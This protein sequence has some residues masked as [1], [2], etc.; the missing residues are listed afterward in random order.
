MSF[1]L[2]SVS[3]LA[4]ALALAP[5]PA[6]AVPADFRQRAEVQL[7]A[8]VPADGPGLSAIVTEHGRTVY[9][10]A[11]GLANVEAH[12]PV[13][14]QTVFRLGSIT[15]Q[16]TS[17]VIMQLVDEGRISL[18]DPLSRFLPD[19]P[20]PAAAVTVRQLLSHTGGIAN[21]TA[22]PGWM[23]EANT[24]RPHTTAEMVGVFSAVPLTAPAG[25]RWQ[26]SN[27][28]Y[29][30]LAAIIERV[31]GMPW[32]EAVARRIARPLGLATIRYGVGEESVPHMAHGYTKEAGRVRPA[33]LIHMSVPSGA[34][35]L[36]GS[37]ADLARWGQAL[38]HGRVVS[39]A[40][41]QKMIAPTL[42]ADGSTNPYGFGLAN[43][44]IRGRRAI[45]HN[46]GIYGFATD[47]IYLP[48]QDLFVA[49]LANSDSSSVSPGITLRRLAAI[50]LGDP[51]PTFERVP[52]D[53]AAVEPF[54]GVYAAP[55]PGGERRFY[56]R[57]GRLFTRRAA[58][59]PEQEVFAAGGNRFFYGPNSLSWF[60]VSRDASGAITMAAH[61]NGEDQIETSLRT[62]AAPPEAPTVTVSPAILAS[63]VGTYVSAGPRIAVALGEDGRLTVTLGGPR[64]LPMRAISETEFQ[65]EAADV[66]VIFQ[67][68]N[69][70]VTRL[71]VRQGTR[72]MP[73]TREAVRAP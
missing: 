26:Y 42:L 2:K 66:R 41:Y 15:K 12:T 43:T 63:Y 29:V 52:V 45:T 59:G 16:F 17:A 23:V 28:G 31:T 21:Y 14:P 5:F 53:V 67:R 1:A 50:A 51:Y 37:A 8:T 60:T 20:Q 70:A 69:G 73:A 9:A 65:L 61:P 4:V 7:A 3:L 38:H 39:A 48:D 30:L 57:D 13:T 68:E 34:G 44:Q 19:Y 27:S 72:E 62:G 47:S 58:G 32:H 35:A 56:Q 18:D 71:L 10:G 54:L 49:V 55:G 6:A 22:I 46:G 11:R 24:N 25:T 36:I 40:S 33:Q 64:P